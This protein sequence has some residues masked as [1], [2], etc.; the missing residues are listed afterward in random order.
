MYI[1]HGTK[2][3]TRSGTK[4]QVNP[5]KSE[6]GHHAAGGVERREPSFARETEKRNDII[7]I[8]YIGSKKERRNIAQFPVLVG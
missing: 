8:I 4:K 5:V 6:G 3:K 7:S 2:Y 1:V